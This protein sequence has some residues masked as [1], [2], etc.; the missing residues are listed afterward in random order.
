MWTDSQ[1]SGVIELFR[2]NYERAAS[3]RSNSAA[4]G[5]EKENR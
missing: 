3:A 1:V 4:S 5:S 2:Q